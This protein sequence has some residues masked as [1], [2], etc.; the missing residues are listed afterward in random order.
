MRK[1]PFLLTLSWSKGRSMGGV[2]P[3]HL[4]FFEG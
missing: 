2:S 1:K 3:Q 4:P